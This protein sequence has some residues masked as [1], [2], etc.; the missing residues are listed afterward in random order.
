MKFFLFTENH[1]TRNTGTLNNVLRV[2]GLD[3]ISWWLIF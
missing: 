2:L 1:M 3:V